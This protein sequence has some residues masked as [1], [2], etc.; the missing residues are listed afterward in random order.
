MDHVIAYA[1]AFLTSALAL[2][3]GFGLGTILTPVFLLFYDVKLAIFLVAI[4]HFLNNLL[5]FILFRKHFDF[6]ILKRFGLMAIAGAFLGAWIQP[7]LASQF[8][9]RAIGILL[10][11]LALKEIIPKIQ[12]RLPRQIDSLGGFLSG[13]LGG[14]IGNQGAIRSAFLLNYPISKETFIATGVF[15]A[16]MVDLTRIP[17]Y[18]ISYSSLLA[19]SSSFVISMIL[20]T[21]AGTIAG[22]LLLNRFSVDVFR[23]IVAVWILIMGIYF[24]F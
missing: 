24:I 8:L 5:K 13:F 15:I 16:C 21:F 14:L 9:K 23:R 1:V 11:F 6:K 2:F 17:I 18:W 3:S 19:R 7:H 20:V 10:I 4:V 12:F 22:R